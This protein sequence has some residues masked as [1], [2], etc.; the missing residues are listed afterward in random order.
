MRVSID[1]RSVQAGDYFIPVKGP[2]FDG[3]DFVQEAIRKGAHVL[4]VDLSDFAKQYRKKLNCQV[5]GITGSAGKTTVKDLL[6]SV[7]GQAYK[8]VSTQQNL[9]NEIGVPLTLLGA[10]HDTDILIVEMGMRHAGEIRD[11]VRI[12]RPTH[13][14]ITSIGLTHIENF[15]SP[16]DIAKAKAEAFQF[17]LAWEAQRLGQKKRKAFINFSSGYPDYLTKV[18][19]KKGYDVFPFRGEDKP[20]QNMMLCYTVGRH[21]NLT[22]EQIYEGISSFQS[23]DHRMKILKKKLAVGECTLIDDT[24]N[25]N[26]DGMQ[27]ALQYLRYFT[28]RK[29][30]VLGDMLELGDYSSQAHRDIAGYCIDAGVQLLFTFGKEMKQLI[31]TDLDIHSF[32]DKKALITQLQSELKNGDVILF[33]GSRGMKM[34]EIVDGLNTN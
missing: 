7:L 24:Y 9:N 22:D 11:L 34:E 26:P 1:S 31:S 20:E 17:P 27:Y 18:A 21:F 16:K 2:R 30:A 29:I 25:A 15:S 8:V 3:R 19:Q 23:S 32:D 5:I 4:D 14:V 28:G 6:T 13:M 12:L 33:K 10:D